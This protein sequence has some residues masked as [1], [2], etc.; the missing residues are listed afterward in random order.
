MMGV[1]KGIGW[2]EHAQRVEE[3][4]QDATKAQNEGHR[5][6]TGIGSEGITKPA[7]AARDITEE[8]EQVLRLLGSEEPS[9]PSRPSPSPSIPSPWPFVRE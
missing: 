7:R 4:S 9:C 1:A 3:I 6:E 8:I 5:V 2:C